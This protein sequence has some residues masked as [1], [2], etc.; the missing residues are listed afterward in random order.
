MTEIINMTG[1][2]CHM[3]DEYNDFLVTIEPGPV[4]LQPYHSVDHSQVEDEA[5]VDGCLVP[6]YE[7]D[8][9]PGAHSNYSVASQLPPKRDDTLVLVPVWASSALIREGLWDRDD[10]VVAHDV[11][12]GDDGKV[13]GCRG[14]RFV[15]PEYDEDFD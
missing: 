12:R 3:V 15:L 6:V 14:L 4:R 7:S 5:F 13:L 9:D 2:P 10:V 8:F 11:V 1:N